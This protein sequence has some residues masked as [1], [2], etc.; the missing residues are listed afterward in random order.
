MSP[1]TMLAVAAVLAIAVAVAGLAYWPRGDRGDGAR[2]SGT[3]AASLL[4]G[5]GLAGRTVVLDPGHNGGNGSHSADIG[6]RVDAGGFQ[7]ECDTVGAQTADGYP[8]HAFSFDVATRA[9]DALRALGVT[10][11]LTRYDDEGVGPCVDERARI[12]NAAEADAVVSIHA[13]GGPSAGSGFHVIAP[14]A[15]PDGGNGGILGASAQLADLLRESFGAA[16]GQPRADYLG[17]DGITVR[18]DL[19]GLNLSRVPKVFLECGNMR[20]PGDAARISDPA[21]RQQAAE[22]LVDGLVT[23]LAGTGGSGPPSTGV[24]AQGPVPRPRTVT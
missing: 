18:S 8:E 5:Q 24:G 20:N 21:W 17:E 19:G 16:T 6:R 12:G 1:F 11:I 14:A 4:G 10:V 3:E 22:G 2:R 9:A 7:K 23:F 13:D 15:S